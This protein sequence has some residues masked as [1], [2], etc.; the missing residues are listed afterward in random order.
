MSS[1]HLSGTRY[2][3]MLDLCPYCLDSG[4]VLQVGH[5]ESDTVFLAQQQMDM[6]QA[7]TR[8]AQYNKDIN[9]NKEMD[10]PHGKKRDR[11]KLC[12]GMGMCV[13]G[14]LKSECKDCGGSGICIHGRRKV[15]C[16]ECGGTW[17]CSGRM[18]YFSLR[19]SIQRPVYATT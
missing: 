4:F 19:S 5:H 14:R 13:H 2:L 3:T 10:C 7:Q 12:G 8:I 18:E 15:T 17:R 1:E 16:K 11:C 6:Q 9:K